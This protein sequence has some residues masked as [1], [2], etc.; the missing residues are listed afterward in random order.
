MADVTP[1]PLVDG[2]SENAVDL[3]GPLNETGDDLPENVD[4]VNDWSFAFVVLLRRVCALA[5]NLC[6]VSSKP[7]R[8]RECVP[9]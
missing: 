4:T 6:K 5:T 1:P 2:R 9:T 8:E 7:G 3:D